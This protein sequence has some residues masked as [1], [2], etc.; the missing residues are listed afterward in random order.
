MKRFFDAVIIGGGASGL[1]CAV[2]A[3]KNNKNLK[4]AVIEKNDRVGKK[5]LATGNGRCNLTNKNVAPGFYRGSFRD[6][7]PYILERISSKALL[8]Y[9]KSLGLLSF[10]DNE[11]RYYPLSRQASSVLDILRFN[12]E[13][14]GA[15]IFCDENIKSIRKSGGAFSVNTVSGEFVCGKLI[16]A[17]GSK[18]APKLGGNS[19]AADYLK[20]LGH[21]FAPFSPALCPVK[22][23][24]PLLK[25]LKGIRALGKVSL[26]RNGK[27][28]KS[29]NGEIQFAENA[30]SGI[31]VFNLSLYAKKNDVISIDLLPDISNK[32]L[33][34]LLR[35]N[36]E[37]FSGFTCDNLLTGI[38]QK[39]LAQAVMKSGKV[40]DFSNQCKDITENE[41]NSIS[42]TLKAFS[43][44]VDS[45]SGFENAQCAKGGVA[46]REIDEKTMQSRICKNLYICGEAVDICGECGGFNLHFAFASGIIAGES[47]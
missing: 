21:S 45:L 7:M 5:L 25:S 42:K 37:R 4:I 39:R 2:A 19:S 9:F 17:C 16:I 27:A 8:D 22:V 41:L 20:N 35:N 36:K 29:E 30:L 6:K 3:K 31:C 40:S 28:I 11:G 44:K 26:F 43:F 15:E 10:C 14:L 24:S 38:L 18:A 34:R 46:A 12:C 47:L 13:T 33:F 23:Q 1:M 32:E